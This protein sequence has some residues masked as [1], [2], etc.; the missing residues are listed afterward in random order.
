VICPAEVVY[1]VHVYRGRKNKEAGTTK[2]NFTA[3]IVAHD[4]ITLKLIP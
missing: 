1:P 2:K 3:D 4:V